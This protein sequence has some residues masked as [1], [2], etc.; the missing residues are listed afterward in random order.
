MTRH[1]LLLLL[2]CA[3]LAAA[4]PE[5]A[6][7]QAGADGKYALLC[8]WRGDAAETQAFRSRFAAAAAPVAARAVT[9]E[10]G[11]DDPASLPLVRR[12]KLERAPLPL[13]LAVAPNGAVTRAFPQI[14]AEGFAAAFVGP[15]FA[16]CLKAMQD[17]RIAVVSVGNATL[18]GSAETR[19]VADAFAAQ[20]SLAAICTVVAADPAAAAEAE[21]FKALGL[22]ASTDKALIALVVP[23][24]RLL[25]SFSHPVSREQLDAALA[26]AM[27]GGCGPWCG[28]SACP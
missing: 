1:A 12:L 9:V 6:L 25:G 23:P 7:R 22:P 17:G 8:L 27:S 10:V 11:F 21:L 14:P 20:P 26:K 13:V 19:T 5:A 2:A 15:A 4:D 3:G 16:A 24:G 28:D 18:A